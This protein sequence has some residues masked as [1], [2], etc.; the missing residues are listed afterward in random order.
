M[1]ADDRPHWTD[2]AVV[3]VLCAAAILAFVDRFVLSLLVE[4][5]KAD[6]GLSDSQ[7]GLL[8]GVAF[9]LF[10]AA[11]GIPLGWLADRWSRK[12]TILVGMG[13][14]SVATA[15]CGLATNFGQLLLA[16]IGV[17][18]GEAG[19]VPASYAIING[20]FARGRASLAISVFQIGG[21]LG[22][23]LSMLLVGMVYAFFAAGGGADWPLIGHLKPWQQTFIAAAL[24]GIPLML[25]VAPMREQRRTA[26]KSD[27]RP[28]ARSADRDEQPRPLVYALLFFGMA[29]QFACSYALLSW[30]PAVLA[31][32]HGWEPEKIGLWY[33]LALL[34]VA[35]A[36]VLIGGWTADRMLMRGRSDSHLIAPLVAAV[37]ALPLFLAFGAA[38]AASTL[39]LIATALHVVLGLPMGVAPALIQRI[40]RADRR[41][42]VSA[43]YVLAC[44]IVSLG[45]GPVLIGWLSS[46]S[47]D[48]PAALRMAMVAVSLPSALLSCVLLFRLRHLLL[49]TPTSRPEPAQSRFSDGKA[50]R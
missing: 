20:R 46:Q 8:H 9:G 24:P 11:M 15:L 3:G 18:A 38:A 43:V 48:D 13:V 4:P 34:V 29:F 39:L 23:G 16:R 25:A 42:R 36:G 33:G 32:E 7:L 31:R 12:G 50:M 6:L 10:Y 2:W 37:C 22:V 28:A 27:E 17:G 19:L 40:T 35:P 26:P 5:I 44:N 41:S 14:W 1:A 47:P 30:M 21:F 45:L 49:S